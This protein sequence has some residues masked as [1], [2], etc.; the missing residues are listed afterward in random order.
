MSKKS[1]LI[2]GDIVTLAILIVVG[3]ATHGETGASYLPR[4]VASLIPLALAWFLLSPWFGLFDE[5]VIS[6][7]K[8][9]LRILLVFLFAAPLAVILRSVILALPVVPIFALILGSTNA[10]GMM[11]W[12]GIYIFITRRS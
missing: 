12:R 5:T 8:H 10:I 7:P 9:L 6:N 1:T 4:M 3:F 2:L 11:L